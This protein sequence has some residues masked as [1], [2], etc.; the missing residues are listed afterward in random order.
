[1]S[2]SYF[3]LPRGLKFQKFTSTFE[4]LKWQKRFVGCRESN[5]RSPYIKRASLVYSQRLPWYYRLRVHH[6]PTDREFEM[7]VR[8]RGWRIT[9]SGCVRFWCPSSKTTRK[10][11]PSK[12]NVYGSSL[13]SRSAFFDLS[14]KIRRY[15]PSRPNIEKDM[16]CVDDI[17]ILVQRSML[18]KKTSAKG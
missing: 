15:E 7:E 5:D 18:P 6:F 4:N 13:L 14:T 12:T 9:C 17:V 10:P 2:C 8:K 1:M 11:S 3:V 16:D